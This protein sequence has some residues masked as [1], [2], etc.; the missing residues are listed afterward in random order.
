VIGEVIGICGAVVLG[1][2]ATDLLYRVSPRDPV[3]LGLVGAFLFFVIGYGRVYAG[4][5]RARWCLVSSACSRFVL[6]WPQ[7]ASDDE[8]LIRSRIYNP[9]VSHAVVGPSLMAGKQ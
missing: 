1:W 2:L 8:G 7:E 3:V 6:E 9:C 4:V 5:D